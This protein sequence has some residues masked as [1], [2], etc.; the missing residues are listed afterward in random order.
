MLSYL[1]YVILLSLVSQ[2][3]SHIL[4]FSLGGMIMF[5]FLKKLPS[6]GIE[7]GL[8]PSSVVLA[9]IRKRLKSRYKYAVRRIKPRKDHIICKKIGA[10]LSS[11]ICKQFW[12]EVKNNIKQSSRTCQHSSPCSCWWIYQWDMVIL[13]ICLRNRTLLPI[14][15]FPR[16]IHF[17]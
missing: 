4:K 14:P 17:R 12:R 7:F 10:T 6:F 11:K 3:S 5:V 9:Q 13:P 16:F 1:A 2:W 8:S 15:K